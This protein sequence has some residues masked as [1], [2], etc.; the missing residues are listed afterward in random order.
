MTKWP[1]LCNTFLAVFMERVFENTMSLCPLISVYLERHKCVNR[2]IN[3][4]NECI[5]KL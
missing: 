5:F 3:D 1:P 2:F 4:A